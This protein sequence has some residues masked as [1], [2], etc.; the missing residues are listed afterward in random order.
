[1]ERRELKLKKRTLRIDR[2]LEAAVD[3]LPVFDLD[4]LHRS[5]RDSLLVAGLFRRPAKYLRGPSGAAR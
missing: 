2:R 3:V 5:F 1:M 4:L